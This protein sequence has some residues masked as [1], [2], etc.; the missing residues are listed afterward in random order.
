MNKIL[1]WFLFTLL[2]NILTSNA[3]EKYTLSGTISEEKSNETLI[4]VNI[5]FPE[6]QSG[7]TTNEYGFYSITLP[8]GTYKTIV[9]YL[10]YTTITET[11]VL[12]ENITKNY[13]LFDA[14]ENLDA[15]IITEN[16]EKLD[17]QTPQMSVNKL[18]ST[19]IKQIPVVLGEEP[20]F[21]KE[22]YVFLSNQKI[23]Q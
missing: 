19:T 7:T 23:K 1:L 22:M 13:A 5:L 9:S 11:I 20:F 6:I 4:G 16:I 15:V 12:S 21:F 18:T 3:Q 10:G 2:L 17:I 8:E 14:T